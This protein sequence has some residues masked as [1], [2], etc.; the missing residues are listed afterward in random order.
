MAAGQQLIET[1]KAVQYALLNLALNPLVFHEENVVR[2]P[3]VCVR[4]NTSILLCHYHGIRKPYQKWQLLLSAS[5]R[6]T[7]F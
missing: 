2:E 6:V 5:F 1:A 3:L 4:T 7:R